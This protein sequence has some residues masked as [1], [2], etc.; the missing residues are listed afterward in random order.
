LY[1]FCENVDLGAVNRRII[2]SLIRAG[3]M[4]AFEGSRAQLMAVLD[5]AMEGGQRAWRDRMNGQVG[6]FGD[7]ST[8]EEHHA[9][10]P[11]PK[12]PDWSD[13]EKLTGEKELLGFYVTGH[14][15]DQY[16]D[17]VAELATHGT[18]NLEGLNRGAEVA[19]C[20]VLRGIQRRRNRDQKP[21]ASMTLE[22]RDGAVEA[23]VFNTNYE[24][25]LPEIAEDQAVLVRGLV[26]PEDNAPPKI[27]VQDIVLLEKAA[28]RFA[29]VI[30]V[31]VW[32]GRN[33]IDR[34]A[35]LSDLFRSKPG[36]TQVRLRLESPRD[37]VVY[38]DVPAKVRPD[39]EFKIALEK[40][41][42]PDA[43]E[44]LAS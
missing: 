41:C 28:L 21:W 34:A 13:R 7:F 15:L 27:S 26:L 30:T 40:I 35:A 12:V 3:A 38:L 23:M 29:S 24:R 1:Q 44:V 10:K 2:E 25:L 5:G 43:L 16:A 6:L 11:L 8:P 39:R 31:R 14:P 18:G 33:G 19:L 37:F 9:P 17:K 22:D 36:D 42:G 32:L 4:D 20:G